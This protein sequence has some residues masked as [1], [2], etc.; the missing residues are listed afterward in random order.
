MTASIDMRWRAIVLT[1]VYGVDAA[2]AAV[3]LGVSRRSISRWS[4]LFQRQGNV[5]P[6][7]GTQQ[8]PRWPLVCLE[9]VNE[10]LRAHPCF[11]IE[12]L[13]DAIK[14]KFPALENVSTS[15]I[16]R[17]LR[18]DLGL[19]RKVLTKRARE[20]IPAEIEL[21]YWKLVP[22]YGYPEQLV[23]VDETA[24]DGRD[25]LCR[26]AWSARNQPAIVSQPFARGKTSIPSL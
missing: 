13:Q 25:V 17:V 23:F 15:T 6:S 3:V 18:F 19:T 14:T 9:Y 8:K 26:H 12:E 16:C 20:S 2:V 5:I 22:F 24:K 1:Y 11:Y 4:A 7:A 21:F 10:Y